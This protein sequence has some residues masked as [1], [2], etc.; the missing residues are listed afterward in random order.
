MASF[1]VMQNRINKFIETLKS[2]KIVNPNIIVTNEY[3]DDKGNPVVELHS[4]YR[5]FAIVYNEEYEN[6]KLEDLG[7]GKVPPGV[8]YMFRMRRGAGSEKDFN[9]KVTALNE[10][11]KYVKRKFKGDEYII[12]ESL[13]NIKIQSADTIYT[14]TFDFKKKEIITKTRARRG[15]KSNSPTAAISEARPIKKDEITE[16]VKT[17]SDTAASKK[18]KKIKEKSVEERIKAHEKEITVLEK[19]IK[20]SSS[21]EKIDVQFAEDK[22]YNVLPIGATVE[23][24]YSHKRYTVQQDMKNVIEV[25]SSES[26]YLIMARAD[27]KIIK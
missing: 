7:D 19:K 27:L 1:K 22:N 5:N 16:S 9:K 13:D 26:G 6:N 14:L 23:N 17:I 18:E 12:K 8:D 10:L 21:S 4:D 25:S 20:S 3:K 2:D 15:T 11:R 24:I